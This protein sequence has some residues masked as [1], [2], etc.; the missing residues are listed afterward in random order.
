MASP[1]VRK[2]GRAATALRPLLARVH[3]NTAVQGS[4]YVE[5]GRTKVLASVYGPRELV[6]PSG[7][8]F[9][10]SGTLTADF[11]YAPFARVAAL[12]TTRGSSRGGAQIG[13]GRVERSGD[14]LDLER[15]QADALA[16]TLAP[17]VLLHR[18]PKSGIEVCVLV[19]QSD[20][21]EWPACVVASSLALAD[22]GVEQYGLVSCVTVGRRPPPSSSEQPAAD[23]AASAASSASGGSDASAASAAVVAAKAEPEVA[24]PAP[25]PVVLVDLTGEEE[26]AA[27]STTT[28]AYC[29]AADRITCTRHAGA[30][31]AAAAVGDMSLALEACGV[32][33]AEMRRVL[34]AA[35]ARK[36]KRLVDAAATSS[37]TA[38]VAGGAGAGSTAVAVGGR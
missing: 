31:T 29:R 20:G 10:S 19:L 9:T 3:V 38:A 2:E 4:A 7:T 32:V 33:E 11:K 15:L 30:M 35:E 6:R 26:A 24:A 12:S 5:W 25:E 17:A 23:G 8:E 21:G 18:Y 28:L 34:V 14:T 13:Q 36:G 22:A 1:V 37:S 16:K 27:A